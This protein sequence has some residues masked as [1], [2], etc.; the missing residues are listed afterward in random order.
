VNTANRSF[1]T[2]VTI[3]LVPYILFGLFGCGVLAVALYRVGAD[4]LDGLHRPGED[5]RL[6][7]VFFAVVAI[8][9]V[10]AGVSVRRQV[11][12]TRRLAAFVA[13]HQIPS[14]PVVDTTVR[15]AGLTGRVDVLDD[16]R[17]F[18]FTYGVVYPRVVASRGLIEEVTSRELDAVL[19]HERYHVRNFDT[20]KVVVARAAPAAFFFLPVLGQLRERY[21]AGREL[22]ADRHAVRAHGEAPLAGA[23]YKVLDGPAWADV[24]AAAALGGAD[25]LAQRVAQ[26]E[27]GDEP[28]LDPV[29]RRVRWVTAIGLML[30]FAVFAGAMV[31]GDTTNLGGGSMEMGDWAVFD[32]GMGTA[33]T[34]VGGIACVG[35]W[36]VVAIVAWRAWRRSRVSPVDNPTRP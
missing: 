9:T 35:G 25:F 4:G 16:A 11:V 27:T 29:P 30:L 12:A 10:L 28:A 32:G 5:L 13:E 26:L 18:S 2:L 34:I 23:L 17:P 15:R 6:V 24:G 20:L 1:F 8:G 7:V 36:M 31:S 21:L 33:A 14:A 22:A 19:A 3:A